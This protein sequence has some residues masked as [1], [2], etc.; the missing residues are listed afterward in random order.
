MV[1]HFTSFSGECSCGRKHD[2]VTR[3]AVIEPG[4]LFDFE[5]YMEEFGITG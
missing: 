1:Y 5:K 4:C 2:L 3:A